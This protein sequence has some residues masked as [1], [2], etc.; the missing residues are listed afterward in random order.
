MKLR[1]LLFSFAT[2]TGA[3]VTS[4]N[5]SSPAAPFQ[6]WIDGTGASE[7]QMQLQPY[8]AATYLIRQ[9]VRTHFE[10]P[11][12]Y[13]VFGKDRALLLETGA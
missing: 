10:A 1:G 3:C 7:P 11:F 4:P 8:D 9:S 12:I 13:L 5:P 2:L 6:H